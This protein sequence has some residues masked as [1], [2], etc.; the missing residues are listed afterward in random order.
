[1]AHAQSYQS[2]PLDF[3]VIW[4]SP[5]T[6]TAC[7]HQFGKPKVLMVRP[8]VDVRTWWSQRQADMYAGIP[9][10]ASPLIGYD[11]AG[12]ANGRESCYSPDKDN[13]APRLAIWPLPM[14]NEAESR[15]L[16]LRLMSSPYKA[17]PT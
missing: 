17:S 16:S 1:M 15:S 10:K 14:R 2:L 13:F 11:L 6:G 3:A 12:K 8:T 7:I 5:W 9:S 4:N